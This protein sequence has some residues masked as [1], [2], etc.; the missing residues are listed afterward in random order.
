MVVQ[1]TYWLWILMNIWWSMY[2]ICS[3]ISNADSVS[4]LSALGIWK[5]IIIYISFSS[6]YMYVLQTIAFV[7]NIIIISKNTFITNLNKRTKE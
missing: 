2:V 1:Y 5:N 4:I 7:V 6:H 3:A